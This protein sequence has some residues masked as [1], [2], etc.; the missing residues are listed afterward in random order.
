MPL[1]EISQEA[2]LCDKLGYAR[3][4]AAGFP[5]R[6]QSLLDETPNEDDLSGIIELTRQIAHDE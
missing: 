2:L 5:P 3:S 6:Q 1:P 4:T